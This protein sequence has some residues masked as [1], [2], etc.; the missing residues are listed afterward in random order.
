MTPQNGK[1]ASSFIKRPKTTL[2]APRSAQC[3]RI[4]I[5]CCIPFVAQLMEI[6]RVKQPERGQNVCQDPCGQ[7]QCLKNIVKPPKTLY[8]L[9]C[10]TACDTLAYV[11]SIEA[12]V[13][14]FGGMKPIFGPK[15]GIKILIFC[16]YI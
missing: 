2:L 14:D 4:Q 3:S 6:K 11:H 1:I 13:W 8:Y 12:N 16:Y 15:S 5:T 7:L 9:M 10:T